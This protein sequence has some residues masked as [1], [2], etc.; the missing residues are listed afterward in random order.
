M[1][2]PHFDGHRARAWLA[3]IL[4]GWTLVLLAVSGFRAWA[5][6]TFSVCPSDES[7]AVFC[8]SGVFASALGSL[9]GPAVV[10]AI[11]VVVI[12]LAWLWTMM[13]SKSGA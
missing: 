1:P 3:G 12:A 2:I 10:Y 6:M 5:T 8:R 7:V 11:G 9:E 4:A 13:E